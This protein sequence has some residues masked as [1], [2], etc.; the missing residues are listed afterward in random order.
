MQFVEKV[1]SK[2]RTTLAAFII[3][4]SSEIDGKTCLCIPRIESDF[5]GYFKAGTKVKITIEEWN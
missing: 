1:T 5:D 2:P 4:T 3:Q